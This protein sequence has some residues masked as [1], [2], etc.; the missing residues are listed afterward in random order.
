[1]TTKPLLYYY[2]EVPTEPYFKALRAL[3]PNAD[4]RNYPDW[5][6]RAQASYAMVW[7]P[8]HGLLKAH[9][10]IEVIFSL[11][12]GVDHLLSDPD[13]PRDVPIVRMADTG[14]KEGMAEHVTMHALMH[15][16]RMT[17]ILKNQRIAHWVRLY[18]KLSGDVT[19]GIMGYGVLGTHVAKHLKAFGFPI[20]T[21]SGSPKP[22]EHGVS[23]FH[24][25]DQLAAF[26]GGADIIVLL[27][28]ATPATHHILN[29]KTLAYCRH[30]ASIIN[31]GRGAAV[32]IDALMASIKAGHIKSA[33]LDVFEEEPLPADH[34]A[35]AMEEIFVTPHVA[36]VT[37][38]SPAVAYMV[39]MIAA[40]E[41][42]EALSNLVDLKKGY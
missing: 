36:A 6:D 10:N 9:P 7:H 8:P 14:L 38:V 16:R 28:P 2:D 11:G 25:Q 27:L 42:G 23:H 15:Q 29:A 41:R 22:E 18:P 17:D 31:A 21:W 4:I 32:D 26:L 37:Q 30:G 3:I 35:W 1:M 34:P 12:A 5:G 13:L 20:T 39:D 33:S 40:Y 24:G 19:I